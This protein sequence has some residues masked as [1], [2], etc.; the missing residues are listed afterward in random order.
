MH[1]V[2]FLAHLADAPHAHA[3]GLHLIILATAILALCLAWKK[4]G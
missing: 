2:T 1:T 3:E 4:T